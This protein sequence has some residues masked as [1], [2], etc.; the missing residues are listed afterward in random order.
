MPCVWWSRVQ[1]S[2]CL[3]TSQQ[4]GVVKPTVPPA[5]AI[6][7]NPNGDPNA[8]LNPP[9]AR[10]TDSCLPLRPSGPVLHDYECGGPAAGD[11]AFRWIHGSVV[12][13]RNTDPR[14]QVIAYNEDTYILRQNPCVDWQAPFVYLLFG[15][16]G[17]LLIDTGAT[18]NAEH[19]PL[20]RTVDAIIARWCAVRGR[21]SIPLR[22]VLTSGEDV[23]QNQGMAQFAGRAGTTMAPTEL[24]AMKRFYG[25]AESWPEGAGTIDLGRRVIDVLATPGTHKDGV[26]F[27]DRYNQHLYTGDLLYAGRI[28]IAND[29]DYVASLGRL[30]RWKQSHGV[31]WVMGGHVDMM[32]VPVRAYPRFRNYR[33][34]EH[35]LQLEAASVDEALEHA[36]GM[37]GKPGVA[38][39]SD[40]ILLN[41]VGPDELVYR[42]S[43]EFPAID[44]PFWLP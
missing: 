1:G 37:A 43:P 36:T 6:A 25:L 5:V 13:A 24:D 41:R 34:F 21:T 29:R 19:Y 11:I 12:A 27:Y 23:A 44:V 17:A 18:A 15:N 14:I 42:T 10:N 38:F 33:P 3:Q 31:K 9:G 35:V 30:A 32:F 40:F 20:R 22:V 16:E 26:T 7:K 8:N 39:R 2:F 28:E 4:T